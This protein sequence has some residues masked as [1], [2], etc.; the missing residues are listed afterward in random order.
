MRGLKRAILS[1]VMT[2]VALGVP[3][4]DLLPRSTGPTVEVLSPQDFAKIQLGESLEVVSTVTDP[5]GV[6]RVQL[7]E[8]DD[9]YLTSD[10]PRPEGEKAWTLTQTWMPDAP[11]LY[12]LAVVAYNAEGVAST[13]WAVAVEVVEGTIPEGTSVSTPPGATGTTAPPDTGTAPPLATGTPQPPAPPTSTAPPPPPTGTAP[14]PPPPTNTPLPTPL[15]TNTPLPMADLYIAEL[16]VDPQEPQVGQEA[17]ARVVVRNGGNTP[18]P[19]FGLSPVLAAVPGPNA[20]FQV[21]DDLGPLAPGEERAFIRP[22]VFPRP[23]PATMWVGLSVRWLDQDG[24]PDN[25]TAELQVN[26]LP[27]DLP[28]LY[29]AQVALNPSSPE[30]G[31]EVQVSVSL[32]NGGSANAGPFTVTWKSDPDTIGCSWPVDGLAAGHTT[33]LTCIYAYTY[34]DSGQDTYTKADAYRQIIEADEDNNVRYLR[35][36]VRPAS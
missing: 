27:G 13:P 29:I 32:V 34:P 20:A 26:V 10:S 23:G 15:P 4:C 17:Q 8:G 21:V 33:G 36:N 7:Y 19:L 35:V 28:D 6:T 14:P 5:Q 24:N 25:N 31:Q 3:S 9:L 22:I 11:G 2:L 12:T 30:V 18:S 1:I 16:S